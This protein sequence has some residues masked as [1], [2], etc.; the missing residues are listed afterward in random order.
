MPAVGGGINILQTLKMFYR[1]RSVPK[2]SASDIT[3]TANVMEDFIA[4]PGRRRAVASVRRTVVAQSINTGAEAICGDSD[5]RKTVGCARRPT[6]KVLQLL[7]QG[8]P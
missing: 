1:A 8:L 4:T 5:A 7:G 3:E 6:C 2:C